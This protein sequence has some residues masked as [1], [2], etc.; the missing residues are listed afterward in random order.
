MFQTRACLEESGQTEPIYS[1]AVLAITQRRTV[2]RVGSSALRGA[3]DVEHSLHFQ[4]SRPAAGQHLAT[5]VCGQI[6]DGLMERW[7]AS[8]EGLAGPSAGRSGRPRV[9]LGCHY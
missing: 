4:E 8:R 3:L 2:G 7:S 1:F 6:H 9:E 5:C